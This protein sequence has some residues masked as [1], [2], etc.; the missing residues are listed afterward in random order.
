MYAIRSYYDAE[1]QYVSVR[2]SVYTSLVN[3]YK[4]MGGGWVI[5]AQRSA[6]AVDYP[7]EAPGSKSRVAFPE[8][9]RPTDIEPATGYR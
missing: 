2:G 8:P 6:D 3:T 7:P 4:A 1:L 5:E 9:T